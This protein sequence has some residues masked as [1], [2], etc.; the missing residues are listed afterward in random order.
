[1]L[2]A[3]A[4]NTA[5]RDEARELVHDTWLRL[6]EHALTQSSVSI[7]M[8]EEGAPREVT[9]YLA[10]MAQHMAIDAQRRQ[11]RHARYVSGAVLQEQLAPSQSPD[12]AD[13]L[14]YRQALAMLEAAL[15]SSPERSREVFLAHRVHGEK[16]PEIAERIGVSLNTV[17][18]DL[19]LAAG[20]I[21]DALHRW[22]GS[23]PGSADVRKPGRRRSL[24]ALLGMAGLG[25]AGTVGWRQWQDF[26]HTHVQWQAHWSSPRGQQLRQALPDGSVLQLDALSR[27]SAQYFATRRVV[28]LASGAAFF[29][30]MRDEERPFVVNASDVQVTVLGTRFGVEILPAKSSPNRVVVQVESG[31]VRVDHAGESFEIGAGE[32]LL[33][34]GSS[35]SRTHG[36][37]EQAAAWRHG[38]L[39]FDRATLGE[40]LERLARYTTFMMEATPEAARLP[41]SG[42][43][44]IAQAHSWLKALPHALPVTVR[45]QPDGSV[46]VAMTR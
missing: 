30:V 8:H 7:A 46:Q 34:D 2:R 23:L 33:V 22:R 39:V 13:S 40:A 45:R 24:G 44:H 32:G 43:V 25:V 18:R 16:Q 3:A 20:C 10:V 26:R 12:V 29:D 35:I 42:R 14:M 36:R 5:S 11:Q 31:L 38:E 1:M 27:A 41:M 17:E 37:P 4:R 15:Q 19:M 28:Q 9:S 21:E 6:A